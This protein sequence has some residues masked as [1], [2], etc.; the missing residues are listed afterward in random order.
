MKEL[1]EINYSELM[2]IG[3][4]NYE[5]LQPEDIDLYVKVKATYYLKVIKNCLLFF[6]ALAVVSIVAWIVIMQWNSLS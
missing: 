4:K 5:G 2:G 1:K 3:L 6:V